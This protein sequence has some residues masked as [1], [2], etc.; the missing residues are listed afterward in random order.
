ME[1]KHYKN[2]K[3]RV[4]SESF[5]ILVNNRWKELDVGYSTVNQKIT[6]YKHL[7]KYVK[8]DNNYFY[9]NKTFRHISITGMYL[10]RLSS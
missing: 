10:Q 5:T 3:N 1:Q 8:I 2:S 7:Q 4:L 6:I 9:F